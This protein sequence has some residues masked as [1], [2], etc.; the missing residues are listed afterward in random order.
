MSSSLISNAQSVPNTK[1]PPSLLN[2]VGLLHSRDAAQYLGVSEAWLSR[3]RWKRT[4][5]SFI[6]VGGSNGRAV[7]YRREDLEAWIAANRVTSAEGG[8]NVG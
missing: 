3:E 8:H 4:G 7:R 2:R 5:P 6:R 1:N